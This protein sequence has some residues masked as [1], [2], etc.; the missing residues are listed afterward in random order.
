MKDKI[1]EV[2]SKWHDNPDEIVE[3]DLSY[4]LHER[5]VLAQAILDLIAKEL[6]KEKVSKWEGEITHEINNMI[7]KNIG[8]NQCL[9]D[10]KHKL[11]VE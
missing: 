4:W 11:G 2:I 6:P 1:V 9:K 7:Q 10:I 3:G 5:E 8:Y